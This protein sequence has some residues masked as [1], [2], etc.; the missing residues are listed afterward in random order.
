MHIFFKNHILIGQ[1]DK[2]SQLFKQ[3]VTI[4]VFRKNRLT[5]GGINN[6]ILHFDLDT[7]LPAAT[8]DFI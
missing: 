1:T 5:I 6:S 4:D 8:L 2:V 7:N 3:C